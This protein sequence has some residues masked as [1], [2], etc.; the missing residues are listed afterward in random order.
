MRGFRMGGSVLAVVAVAFAMTGEASATDEGA[1]T[2]EGGPSV[3]LGSMSP[4]VGSGDAVKRVS[5]G[6]RVGMRYGFTSRLEVQASGFWEWRATFVHEPAT[7]PSAGGGLSGALTEDVSRFGAS[8]GVRYA[9]LGMVWRM[10]VGVDV[11]WTHTS[12]TERDLLG[13]PGRASLGLN[14]GDG[15]S[16][17]LSLAPFIGLEWLAT[18]RLSFSIVPRVELLVGSPSA[19][20]VI[21]PFT[22]GWSFYWF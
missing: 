4:S 17:Q 8:A 13:T 22:M 7:V 5:F 9:L 16:D 1:V 10:P 12:L 18:D 15:T 20:S 2:F 3:R 11:G 21:V 14:L 6:A 19:V